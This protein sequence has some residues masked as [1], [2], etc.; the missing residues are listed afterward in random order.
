[1]R[2]PPARTARSA[3]DLDS[4]L[5]AYESQWELGPVPL[6]DLDEYLPGPGD[7]R[8][9]G[10]LVELL[11]VAL[12]RGWVPDDERPMERFRPAFPEL[13][14]DPAALNPLAFE[15][16]RLRI[17]DG[18]TV[19]PAEYARRYDVDVRTWPR[20]SP[21]APAGG[22]DAAQDGWNSFLQRAP[23]TARRWQAAAARQPSVGDTFDDF[24][25]VAELGRG[26]FARVFLARQR[27]LA[28]RLVALKIAVGP[29]AE[30]NRLARLQHGHV[31]PV[32]SV[33]RQGDLT[34]VCMPY[35][36]SSTL[37]DIVRDA[38][39]ATPASI[40]LPGGAQAIVSTMLARQAAL[41]TRI[42]GSVARGLSENLPPSGASSSSN[43]DSTDSDRPRLDPDAPVR[44]AEPDLA[45]PPADVR[46][47]S[48][49]RPID[50]VAAARESTDRRRDAT[51]A[52]VEGRV[53]PPARYD[54]STV[55]ANA[56]DS[57][58]SDD[59]FPLDDSNADPTSSFA[60][61]RLGEL[62]RRSYVDA[63][64]RI[65]AQAADGLAH[66]H[67]RG[68]LHRDLKPANILLAHDGRP[69]ILDFNL[70]AARSPATEGRALVGGTLPYM[71]PEQLASL[72]DGR[73][74][75]A[76]SDVFSLGVVLYELL[77]GRPPAVVRGGD[78]ESLVA[79]LQS[80]WNAGPPSPREENPA[81]PPGLDAIVR[82]CLAPAPDDRYP[83]AESLAEDL[84]R[85]ASD[86]PLKHAREGWNKA[87]AGK[88]LRR[89]PRL[90]SAAAVASISAVLLAALAAAWYSRGRQVARAAAERDLREFDERLP[91]VRLLLAPGV[92]EA[93]PSIADEGVVEARR[94]LD[95]YHIEDDPDWR[96]RPAFRH[97]DPADR[98]R[99]EQSASALLT[100]VAAVQPD[101]DRSD[102]ARPSPAP[103]PLDDRRL[104]ALV[105]AGQFDEAV[106]ELTSRL[107]HAPRE[108]ALW[109]ALGYCQ[110]GRRDLA[111]A[112]I[113]YSV[114]AALAADQYVPLHFR[115]LVRLEQQK[116]AAAIEDFSAALERRPGLA[117]IEFHRG[118]AR[119]GLGR[120]AAALDDFQ[121]ALAHGLRHTRVHFLQ[122]R[123]FEA[124]GRRDEAE[125]ARAEG[126]QR[127]PADAQSWVARGLAKLPSD[128]AGAE[129]DFRAALR[130]DPAFLPAL[131]NLTHALSERLHRADEA[132]ECLDRWV[133]THPLDAVARGSR[134]VLAARRGEVEPAVEDAAAALRLSQTPFVLY[135]TGCI[136]ALVADRRSASRTEALRLIGGA[137]KLQPGL[138]LQMQTDPDLRSLQNDL[139]FRRL[140]AAALI[141]AQTVAVD[142]AAPAPTHR[143]ETSR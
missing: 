24:D 53:D 13:F 132:R 27:S 143:S 136:H 110:V 129:D 68:L 25:L 52:S 78:L 103:E 85:Q 22:G 90:T 46:P 89:H 16:Y 33:H 50:S 1:M 114:C 3:D 6:E 4:L 104:R 29:T 69:L 133:A 74:T 35:L 97:L 117:T 60:A 123:S 106:A 102:D 37:A 94:L 30:P 26:A 80:R 43:V 131:A 11:R 84:R 61:R 96:L 34:G 54:S 64:V 140:L 8:R 63:V 142:P 111:Q 44:A 112:E 75:D 23:Q 10:Q 71:A 36:G 66:A 32:Y 51:I 67:E 19:D 31:M 21:P 9:T 101:A 17:Q 48:G 41:D 141:L 7:P 42:A 99:L 58:A 134:G 98:S 105:D 109:L 118:L 55:R 119:Q 92:R 81:V 124:L 93:E 45:R 139:E 59:A 138:A 62:G 126:L 18:R 77:V 5:E 39:P 95:F 20:L 87:R 86:L 100:A 65:M 40:R 79:R 72:L 56:S 135:Q 57:D 38:W 49:E 12:E 47:T 107:Q 125:R 83:D 137:L 82:K 122:A 88:W 130:A 76:R 70:A 116:F 127:T 121:S 113:S 73:S 28:G 15:E 115:G 128:A 120:H 91:R 2:E 108:P 14:D